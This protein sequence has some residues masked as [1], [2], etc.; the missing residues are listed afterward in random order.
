MEM[1]CRIRFNLSSIITGD[2]DKLYV[3]VDKIT[4]TECGTTDKPYTGPAIVSCDIL[5]VNTNTYTYKAF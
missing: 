5:S 2:N 1:N 4:V 3:P